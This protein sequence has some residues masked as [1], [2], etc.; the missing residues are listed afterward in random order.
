MEYT[1][2]LDKRMHSLMKICASH[3]FNIKE[4]VKTHHS[5]KHF[6]SDFR[7]RKDKRVDGV[8]FTV[9]KGNQT[10]VRYNPTWLRKAEMDNGV[11]SA[12]DNIDDICKAIGMEIP[13]KTRRQLCL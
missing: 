3:Y 2:K 11:W 10:I 7:V 1:D 4:G 13:K 6:L 8:A 9:K 5:Q 12:S